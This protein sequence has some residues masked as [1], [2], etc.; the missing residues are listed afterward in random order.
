VALLGCSIFQRQAEVLKSH[1]EGIH[2]SVE[3]HK[4]LEEW[5]YRALQMA[6]SD[7]EAMRI[8][9]LSICERY[10]HTAL[11]IAMHGSTKHFL[12]QKSVEHLIGKMWRGKYGQSSPLAL[13]PGVSRTTP[14]LNT[15][16]HTQL[17]GTAVRRIDVVCSTSTGV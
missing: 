17:R 11:E 6:D 7:A 14:P 9:S 12:S 15:H 8:V 13:E 10:E 3:N 2:T 16:T 1:W 4:T 5:A